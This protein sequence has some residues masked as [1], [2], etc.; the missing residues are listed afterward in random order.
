MSSFRIASLLIIALHGPAMAGETL[1]YPGM[2]DASAAVAIDR[3]RFVVAS[4]E[5][6]ILR[7][8]DK[9]KPGPAREIDL[10]DFLTAPDPGTDG[11]ESDLEGAARVGNRIYW[12]SSHGRNTEAKKRPKRHRLFATDIVMKG[13][14]PSLNTVGKPYTDLLS[15]L[16]Q[17]GLASL[18]LKEAA[19]LAPEEGGLNIEGLA[20]MP[21]GRLLIALRSPV[22]APGAIVV[23]LE[24]PADVIDG[25]A[26]T[27]G[28]PVMLNLDGRG[29]R[30]LDYVEARKDYLIVAGPP[31]PTGAFA[32]Y[33]WSGQA[34]QAP[35]KLRDL[36]GQPEALFLYPDDANT[37]HLLSDDGDEPVGG[38]RCKD[39]DRSR[40]SFRAYTVKP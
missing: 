2:C 3:T 23:P 28:R 10:D 1:H 24:N 14:V 30:S 35:E 34:D 17:P 27:L 13:D 38:T 18:G 33:R 6:N 20:A 25:K 32:L 37:L 8:Y 21:D 12:I 22:P 19:K 9:D 29:I 26:A 36:A 4:D 31:G 7:I 5:D 39:A 11:K 15:A 40:Q 16:T